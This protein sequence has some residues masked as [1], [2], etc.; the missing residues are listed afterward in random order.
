MIEQRVRAYSQQLA[1]L[2]IEH[3]LVE[4][5]ATPRV[6]EVLNEL[7][8]TLAD[9]A[10]TLITKGDGVYYALV[11]RGDCRI[12][13]KALKKMLHCK[14]F[15][16]ASQEEFLALTGLPPGAACIY[17]PQ[18]TQTIIDEKVFAKEYL[19]G[20]SGVF[21]CSVRYKTADLK[22]LPNLRI[23]SITL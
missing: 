12:D 11:L 16:M 14:D 8:L 21:A 7:Q 3:S 13:F 1:E 17:T 22:Q 18:V 20:G 2:G 6:A 19:L 10:P 23:A 5:Q 9:C 4:H 15:R